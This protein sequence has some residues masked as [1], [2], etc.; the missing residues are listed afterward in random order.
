[1]E[2]VITSEDGRTHAEVLPGYAGDRSHG[3]QPYPARLATG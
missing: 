3:L 1:M 2:V